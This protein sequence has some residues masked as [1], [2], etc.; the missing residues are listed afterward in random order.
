MSRAIRWLRGEYPRLKVFPIGKSVQGREISAL[1]IGHPAG[2]TL[3]VGAV[4]GLEWLTGLLLIRFAEELLRGLAERSP[5]SDIDVAKA[6]RSRSLVVIPCLNPD[7]V[8]LSLAGESDYAGW[9]ANANGVDLNHNFDAGWAVLRELER[10]DGI[11]GPGPTRYGGPA[12]ESEPESKAAAAFCLT[13]QPRTLYAFH[14]Q[15]EEIYYHYGE[16]TPARSKLMAQILASSSGYS[17]AEPEG[18]AAHGGL[19][20]WFID[21]F[22]RPGF[23]I[24]IG[25]GQNPLDIRTLQKT[26]EKLE[27]MLMIATLL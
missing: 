3:F 26:Y 22:R 23:T 14:S 20:D 17:V 1:C 25:K 11:T 12:P 18:L 15:G 4:H 9:Q 10:G 16:H 21:H 6:L 5:V 13:Y 19:K 8:E 24:E 2:A 27:E 7:G